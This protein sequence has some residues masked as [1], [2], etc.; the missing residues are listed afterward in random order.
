MTS[1]SF[2]ETMALFSSGISTNS[3]SKIA[4]L[5]IVAPRPKVSYWKFNTNLIVEILK[6]FEVM[7]RIYFTFCILNI[8]ML[9]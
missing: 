4:S 8:I 3:F 7:M 1:S 6:K 5:L 9:I 2:V